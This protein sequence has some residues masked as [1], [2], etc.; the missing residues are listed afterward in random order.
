MYVM[1]IRVNGIHP[2]KRIGIGILWNMK[3]QK[4]LQVRKETHLGVGLWFSQI[5]KQE[6]IDDY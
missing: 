4:D 5:L 3:I 1:F 6:R 2:S